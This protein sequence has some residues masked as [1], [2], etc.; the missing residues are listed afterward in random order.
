MTDRLKIL[1]RGDDITV[2][3]MNV[4]PKTTAATA[5]GYG[6]NIAG[7][8]PF[9]VGG[10]AKKRYLLYVDAGIPPDCAFTGDSNGAGMRVTGSNY[11][12]HDANYIWRGI[13]IGINNRSGGTMGIMEN[14]ISVQAKSGGTVPT[15]RACTFTM[16]NYGTCATESGVADFIH[17]NE[18]AAPTLSYGIRIRNDDQT[19]MGAVGSAILITSA[20][21]SS[22]FTRLINA[23]GAVLAEYDSGTKVCLMSFQGANGTTYYLLHDTDAPTTLSVGTSLT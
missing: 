15:L 23:E 10:A 2:D 6:V 14:L 5:Y 11:A 21:L 13:N 8:S 12:A 1:R 19:G 18:G 22:G 3:S 4:T 16:E 7:G 17:R 9:Y 20:A